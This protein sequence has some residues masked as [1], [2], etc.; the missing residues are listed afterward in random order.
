MLDILF[1]NGAILAETGMLEKGYVAIGAGKIQAMGEGDPPP[2]LETMRQIDLKGRYLSPG[3]IELHTHGGGGHD[4]MDGTAE[5]IKKAARL[6]LYHGVTTLCPTSMACYDAVLYR[7]LDAYL[8][9]KEEK[10]NMPHLA[11]IH[12][13]GPYFSPA[14]AGAQPPDCMTKPF[15]HHAQ[16]ILDRAG[17][18]IAR[19]SCAPEVEGVLELGDALREKGIIAAIAHTDADC[20]LIERAMEHGFT[21]LT[22]FYS[23]MSGLKRVNG[24]RV[25]G[26]VEAGYLYDALTLEII[27]DGIHLP[28]RLLRLI[29]KCKPHKSI[30]LITDSMRSAGMPDGPSILGSL[31]NNFQVIVEDGVA[32]MPDRQSYAGS[33]ATADRLIRVMQQDGGISLFEAVTMMTQNPARLLGIGEHTGSIAVGKEADLIIFDEN[34]HVISSFVSGKEV[35]RE[36]KNE[37]SCI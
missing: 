34:V 20:T 6:H 22:H 28:P 9:A 27:A 36:D 29:L 30:S 8:E 26:A 10:D 14:Q 18:N 25:L 2:P 7:M 16:G 24:M 23:G 31:E 33:V 5:A 4:F 32:K 19:W 1:Y 37:D 11:G 3:F 17:E 35:E 15:P 13:E 12:L 21:H